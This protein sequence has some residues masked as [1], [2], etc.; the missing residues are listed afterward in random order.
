MDVYRKNDLQHSGIKGQKWGT[1]RYQNKDGSLT[2]AGKQRYQHEQQ[3]G[4]DANRRIRNWRTA[5]EFLMQE[6][7]RNH[8]HEAI[9]AK[10]DAAQNKQN[11]DR[12]YQELENQ[13]NSTLSNQDGNSGFGGGNDN[14]RVKEITKRITKR[15]AATPIKD[16]NSHGIPSNVSKI[17]SKA[18]SAKIIKKEKVVE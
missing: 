15:I 8:Y 18:R 1:R 12:Y 5:Q 9:Q 13:I 7:N 4:T 16:A 2:E 17:I 6:K 14:V 10:E 3:K 11:N